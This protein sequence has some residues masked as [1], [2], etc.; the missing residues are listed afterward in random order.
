MELFDTHFHIDDINIKDFTSELPNDIKFLFMA[1]SGDLSSAAKVRNFAE[2]LNNCWFACGVHPHEADAANGDF[3]GFAE[4]KGHSKLKAVGEIGLDYF[5]DLSDRE[6]Q[7][8]TFDYFLNLALEWQ[9]PAIIHLR[10]KNECFSAYE[11]ALNLL[12]PFASNGG[13]FVIHCFSATPEWVEK[14]LALGGFLGMTGMVTFKQADNIRESLK[15]IPLDRLVIETDSPYL[16]P[17]PFRGKTNH[18]KYL[19]VIADF[20]AKEKSVP[21]EELSAITTANGK[22][23]Y[24]LD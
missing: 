24:Q 11:D 2:E 18:P 12:T 21:V 20:I 6:S 10:D 7:I 19:P 23:L 9:L 15:Y 3:S 16:A 22:K 14:F 13:R 4:F 8:K 17:V 5:Y 1:V